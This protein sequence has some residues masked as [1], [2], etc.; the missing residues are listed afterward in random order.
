MAQEELPMNQ[1]SRSFTFCLSLVLMAILVAPAFSQTINISPKAL[2][3]GQIP[4]SKVAI[5]DLLIFNIGVQPLK[6]NKV[7]IQGTNASLFSLVSD[8]GSVTLN[9]AEMLVVPIQ[10]QPTGEGAVAAQVVVESNASTSPN[11]IDMTGEGTDLAHGFITFER[12]FGGPNGDGAGSVRITS[13]GGYIIAGSTTRVDQ[14]YS[15]A[16]LIK[17]DAYG[18]IEWSQWYGEEEWSEGFAEVVPTDDGG[19]IAVGSHQNSQAKDEPNV[20]VV[21]T[22]ANGKLLWQKSFGRTPFKPD[23]GSDLIPTGDGGYLIAG[24]STTAQDENAYIIKIDANG[25]LLWDKVYGGSAGENAASIKATGDGGYIFLGSTSSYKSGGTGDY[26]F[27]LVKIDAAGNVIWEKNYGG[28]DWDRG[29]SV[30]VTN[31]GGYLMAGWTASPEFGAVARDICLIKIDAS[32]NKQWQKLFGWEH[33]DEAA[34]LIATADGGYLVV[35]SSERYYD[36][37]L[38]TWR[39]DVYII[40]TDAAGNEEWSKTYGG[41]HNEGASCVRQ[42][43]DG[44]FIV[45]GGTSSYSKDSDVYL[46]KIGRHGGFSPVSGQRP[47]SPQGF[48]LEQNYPNP[49][50]GT[51]SIR[52][53]LPQKTNIRITIYNIHGQVVR[54]LIHDFQPAGSYIIKFDADALPSGLYFYQLNTD[55]FSET[56]RMLLLK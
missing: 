55:D 24:R 5:R 50:N 2:Y 25:N 7:R 23:S 16:T 12:I 40:K 52:Y 26:D 31:D 11:I 30:I 1:F 56:K 54:T 19:Y 49:F 4:E 35:G 17:T 37:P 45:S 46:L 29:V 39:P 48:R 3:F 21:R 47:L 9:L 14:E 18:Q 33:Q 27:Y 42:V 22:D 41:L 32:G 8:P 28:S 13:D 6:I 38:E 53:Q 10:F 34:E 36:A 43:N 51:T 20:F 44:G 15:D